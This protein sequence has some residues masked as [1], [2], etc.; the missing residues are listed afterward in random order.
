MFRLALF[1]TSLVLML[2]AAAMPAQDKADLCGRRPCEERRASRRVTRPRTPIKKLFLKEMGKWPGGK[3]CQA[4]QPEE[5]RSLCFGLHE[6]RARHEGCGA[7]S[8]LAE[9]EEPQRHDATPKEVGSARM[10]LKYVA[11]YEGALGV[12]KLADAEKAKGD[13]DSLPLLGCVPEES[14]SRPSSRWPPELGESSH[15]GR[16]RSVLQQESPG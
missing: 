5:G 14:R 13:Q 11:K 8:S 10:V 7:R 3:A 2:S 16:C 6:E 1:V 15:I 4:L 12:V 9:D